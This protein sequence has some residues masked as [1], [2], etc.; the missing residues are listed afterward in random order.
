M[1][2]S[3]FI[4]KLKTKL[5]S[6]LN[7]EIDEDTLTKYDFGNI[8]LY[9]NE[10]NI[11]NDL[12]E[13]I[14]YII[15]PYYQ[16]NNPGKLNSKQY[17][18][19]KST[20]TNSTITNAKEFQSVV[21]KYNPLY[22]EDDCFFANLKNYE[23]K[24]PE[25]ANKF[26]N[27][28]LPFI[29]EQALKLPEYLTKPIPLLGKNMNIAITI[30]KLQALSLL[31]NQF[32]CIFTDENHEIYDTPP[33][34]FITLFSPMKPSLDSTVEKIRTVIH[35]FDKMRKRNL[36]EIKSELLTYQRISLNK[37]SLIDWK[38]QKKG[39]CSVRIDTETSIE[40]CKGMMQVDFAN[41]YLGGG[42]LTNGCVQEEIRFTINPEL[43]VSMIFTQCLDHLESAYIIGT[44]RFSNYTGYGRTYAYGGDY[45]DN[46]TLFDNMNR[47]ETEI[48]AIDATLFCTPGI[49]QY[50]EQFSNKSV[51]RELNKFYAGIKE[52]KYSDLEKDIYIATGNW[53]CGA[54]NGNIELKAL[55]QV[56]AASVVGKNIY[57]CPYDKTE[58]ADQFG[59]LLKK[60]KKL[61]TTTDIL[62]NY[63]EEYYSKVIQNLPKNSKPEVT[64][65]N[66][67]L[68]NI[69]NINNENN[70]KSEEEKVKEKESK[71]KEKELNENNNEKKQEDI[72]EKKME[73]EKEK[74]DI[75]EKEKEK[76]KEIEDEKEKEDIEEK[77]KEKEIEDEKEKEDIKEKEKE[78]E[79]EDEKE[80]E[81]IKEKEKE[82]EIE[83]EKEK[84]DIKEKEKEIEDEKEKEDIKEKEKE[85]EDEKEKEDIKEKEKEIEDEKEKE[86]IKE[87]EKEME[88]EKEKED[89]KEKE[90]EKEIE[91]EKEKEDIK[92]KEKEI[93]DEKEKEEE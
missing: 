56:I 43:F 34:S 38:N 47:K 80:K 81:D 21:I 45:D 73:N 29:I 58:F 12:K 27:K 87:K 76:E 84:E 19:F 93:E 44:E 2:I 4:K 41:W 55:L 68:K 54:F 17:K 31:A 42:V 40:D 46:G 13:Y 14:N 28:I 20:L 69:E 74:E 83:D 52:N 59:L 39:L 65:F 3:G 49:P 72:K 48:V 82:K 33:C 15:I 91:D 57:Y 26:F 78:K 50:Y 90:K 16:K 88:D 23:A 24:Y 71:I 51:M 92:E 1:N 8:E 66:Y 9:N 36:E 63:I 11:N 5:N 53:G 89:I 64:L 62:F 32:L 22:T 75:K 10:L 77:E 30:N 25:E 6:D 70:K 79:I 86:D 61:H 67:I 37:E 18:F 85:M 35:Y 7:K 60:L